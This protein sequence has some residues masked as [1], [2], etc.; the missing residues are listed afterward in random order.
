ME[1]THL[2]ETINDMLDGE[3][4]TAEQIIETLVLRMDSQQLQSANA[5]LVAI[6]YN[7]LFQPV[8]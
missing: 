7:N 8:D 5:E 3:F 1:F 6:S 2:L 4:M